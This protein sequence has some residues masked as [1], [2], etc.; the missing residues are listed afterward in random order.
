MASTFRALFVYGRPN[1]PARLTIEDLVE[2]FE[3]TDT[4][5][6]VEVSVRQRSVCSVEN[7]TAANAS[8]KE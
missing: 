6:T 3:S 4:V 2:K 5:Q 7:I 1:R 8:I